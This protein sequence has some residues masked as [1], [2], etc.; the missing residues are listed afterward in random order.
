MARKSINVRSLCEDIIKENVA[1]KEQKT[2]C[3]TGFFEEVEN[4]LLCDSKQ[5]GKKINKKKENGFNQ[6]NC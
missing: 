2:E 5:S 3:Y 6:M 1:E 4:L